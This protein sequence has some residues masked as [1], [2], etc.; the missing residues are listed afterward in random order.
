MKRG[1][2]L[3]RMTRRARTVHIKARSLAATT[4]I[5]DG[6]D[7]SSEHSLRTCTQVRRNVRMQKKKRNATEVTSTVYDI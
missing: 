3:D 1:A 5:A 7:I 4:F 6:T 2:S